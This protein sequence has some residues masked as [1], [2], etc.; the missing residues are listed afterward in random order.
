MLPE[1]SFSI[2]VINSPVFPLVSA[3]EMKKKLHSLRTSFGKEL[4]KM[5]KSRKSGSGTDDVYRPTYE[6][7]EELKFLLPVITARPSRS[8]AVCNKLCQAATLHIVYHVMFI[9]FLYPS[10][11]Q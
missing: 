3:E 9:Y 10:L 8:N 5:E 6:F 4:N 11:K 1:N 7:Y 2:H